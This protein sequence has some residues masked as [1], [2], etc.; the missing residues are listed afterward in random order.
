M[1]VPS[2]QT[3][4]IVV[5]IVVA[6]AAVAAAHSFAATK[7]ATT[8]VTA[9]TTLTGRELYREFC[10]QCHALATALAAGFGSSGKLGTLGG[11]S[12]NTLRVP[13]EVS[14]NAV[15]EPTGGHAQVHKA[16]TWNQLLTVSRY[17]A[18]ATVHHPIPALPTDG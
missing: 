10:G 3:L 1:S 14:V 9:S 2:R 18:T 7:P 11:P 4:C 8:T 15:A 5:S 16:I 17:I 6:V 12:F 13:F